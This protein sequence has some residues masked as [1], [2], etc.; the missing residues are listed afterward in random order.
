MSVQHVSRSIRSLFL[1]SRASGIDRHEFENL[2]RAELD[3]LG[4]VEDQEQV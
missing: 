1:L 4:M 2:V 3:I